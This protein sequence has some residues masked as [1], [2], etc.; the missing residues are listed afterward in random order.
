M[1]NI[2]FKRRLSKSVDNK[3]SIVTIPRAIAQSWEQYATVNLVFNGDSLVITPLDD[4]RRPQSKEGATTENDDGS[5]FNELN[6]EQY[7]QT[8]EKIKVL[9]LETIEDF[10]PVDDDVTHFFEKLYALLDEVIAI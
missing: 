10:E 7:L 9:L 4:E 3:A 1:K 8:L 2:V 5:E 6:E